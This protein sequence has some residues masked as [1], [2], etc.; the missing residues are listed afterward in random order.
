MPILKFSHKLNSNS[1]QKTVLFVIT[2]IILCALVIVFPYEI[3]DADSQVYSDI[4]KQLAYAPII[5]WCAPL[6]REAN[7]GFELFQ[8]HPP[9][10]FWVTAIFVRMGVPGESAA[11][12]ANFL[13]LLLSLYVIY[14]LVSHFGGTV[15]GW[16][17]VFGYMITPIFLQYLIR[18]NHEVPLNLAVMA[19]LYGYVRSNE[20]RKFQ[21][22]FI[23][24]LIFA[25]FTK[26][27]SALAL[28]LIVLL[29]WILY[30]KN[31][32][33]I[34][35]ILVAFIL[36]SGM[37]CLFEF[38]YQ[39]I[40]HG[41]SFWQNYLSW[42]GGLTSEVKFTPLN[43]IIN[44]IWYL[45]RAIWYP[46]PWLFFALYG[47]LKP[48]RT[49][50][51]I[52]NIKFYKFCLMAAALIILCFSLFDRKADRYIFTAYCLIS[53]SGIWVLFSVKPGITQ[54]FKK[55]ENLLCLVFSIILVV[56]SV[57]VI[58]FHAYHYR[59]IKFWPG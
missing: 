42:Q 3:K 5:Q 16:G 21:V 13:Y 8:A 27:F 45:S 20:S 17:A 50:K 55:N 6:W 32:K 40:T 10:I 23:L 48:K 52:V 43:K 33:G 25:V 54:F 4:G 18:A 30:L 14:L 37:M 22:L 24:A 12:C 26:G 7:Q 46:F 15:F 34:V 39:S 47:L 44:F 36:T 38:W 29:Y 41:I 11:L 53:I 28:L 51:P 35:L 59:F 2:Y 57:L 49:T 58:Y 1:L 31:T 56:I 9:G 19:G